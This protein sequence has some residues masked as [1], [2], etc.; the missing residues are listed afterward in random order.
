MNYV[1]LE[2]GILSFSNEK[3]EKLVQGRD[4]EEALIE[5]YGDNFIDVASNVS[6]G[7]YVLS[8][9]SELV[10]MSPE[11]AREYFS[12]I[13]QE[14]SDYMKEE[15]PDEELEAPSE[16]ELFDFALGFVPEFVIC[17]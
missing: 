5:I 3:F 14:W 15:F 13:E 10:V 6:P 11:E 8:E 7:C 1:L 16:E 4:A 12:E 9:S 2:E 17:S